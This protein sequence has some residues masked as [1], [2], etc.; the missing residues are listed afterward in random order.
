MRAW[1][2]LQDQDVK[3]TAVIIAVVVA[4]AV[5]TLNTVR[6]PIE[7]SDITQNPTP[8]G[9]TVSLVI[10]LVPVLAVY[11]W[12]RRQFREAPGVI[13]RSIHAVLVWHS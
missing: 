4:P 5:L 6:L 1:L 3:V 13:R 7:P 2:W 9:Y 8:L 10:Y 11:W 12:F